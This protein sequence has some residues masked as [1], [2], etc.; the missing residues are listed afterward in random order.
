MRS[1]ETRYVAWASR[2][3]GTARIVVTL[4]VGACV[5]LAGL[6]LLLALGGPWLD[7]RLGLPRFAAGLVTTVPGVVL[8]VAGGVLAF[9]SVVA[10]VRIGR[11][12]PVPMIPTQRLVV[13]PPFTYCRNPMVLGTATA[14]LG[15]GLWVGSASAVVF[16]LGF[17][18]LLLLYV[19]V[20]EEKELEA[21]FGDDYVRYKDSTPFLIPRL[22]RR[23]GG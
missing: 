11:G 8:L 1:S 19:K 7:Q 21:R 15:L 16:V 5:F 4:M 12:T 9:W 18:G 22:P 3:P 10:E 14:Y 6:P 2:E 23:G 20:L 17:A 13:V